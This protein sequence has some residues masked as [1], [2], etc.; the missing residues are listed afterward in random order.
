MENLKIILRLYDLFIATDPLMPI[1]LGAVMVSEYGDEIL[2][3]ECDMASLHT[4]ITKLPLR[5][6]DIE[7]IEEYILK[8]LNL[9]KQCPPETLTDL[10]EKWL[11]KW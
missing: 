6:D 7:V 10:N 5:I 9:F 4:V 2:D 1:Y 11:N 8:A 3:I